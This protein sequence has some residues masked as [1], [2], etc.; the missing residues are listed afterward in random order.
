MMPISGPASE[1]SPLEDSWL[2]RSLAKRG[3][4]ILE[5]EDYMVWGCS[6]IY[7][8]A[9]KVHVFFSRWPKQEGHWLIDSRVLT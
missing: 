5:S 1:G 2:S 7:D 4:L 3:T 8:D 6:P 9:G